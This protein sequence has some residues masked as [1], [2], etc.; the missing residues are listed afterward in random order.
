MNIH[1]LRIFI[2]VATYKSVTKAAEALL[3]SQPAVT[4]QIRNLEKELNLKLIKGEGR[5][6]QLTNAGEFVFTQG[7]RLFTLEQDINKKIET[8]KQKKNNELKIASTYAPGNFLLPELLAQYKLENPHLQ[9]SL[10][11]GNVD[12]VERK[13][14]NYEADVGFV[15]NSEIEHNELCYIHLSEL[16]F[17]FIVPVNHQ[18][19]NRTISLKEF[20]KE[21]IILREQGSSTRDLLYA[22]CHANN[23][24]IPPVGLQLQGLN[25]SL[26]AV[27]AG[28]GTMI[29][30]SISVEEMIRSGKVARVYIKNISVYHSIYLC[31]RKD[32]CNNLSFIQFVNK[33]FS[34]T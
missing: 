9:I 27:Q 1:A 15:V 10:A 34:A 31:Y 19:A 4:I 21:P 11:I 3:I 7:K 28:Y 8:F 16:E 33:K 23:C 17:W 26:R 5:G 30:P 14:L 12:L 13:L 24:P 25:E 20:S 6:I 18:F 22:I 2:T 29:A 32:D